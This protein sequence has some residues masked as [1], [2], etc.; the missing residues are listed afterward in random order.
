M[1]VLDIR[2]GEIVYCGLKPY[3]V[4]ADFNGEG[5]VI[6]ARDADKQS[7]TIMTKQL[8]ITQ[9]DIDRR[10]G[11]RFVPLIELESRF[12]VATNGTKRSSLTSV[13]TPEQPC[14]E[15]EGK[16]FLITGDVGDAVK[17]KI[18]AHGGTV[19]P[20]WES[21]FTVQGNSYELSAS[22]VPFLIQNAKPGTT[23][24]PKAMAALAAGMPILSASYIDAAV[25]MPVSWRNF[26]VAS[27]YSAFLGGYASQ[28]I[29]DDWGAPGWETSTAR[30]KRQPL[31]GKSVLFIEPS[32]KYDKGKGLKV[33][34][35]GQGFS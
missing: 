24:T 5:D 32:A 30:S 17:T 31:A 22:G 11:D 1:R 9:S 28:D 26:L 8:A 27:G 6:T 29:A 20:D 7:F 19:V 4:E 21:V 3:T 25:Q 23:I 16:V 12:P 34:Y 14:A 13:V 18:E 2:K 10:Y 33:S 15:F 35:C